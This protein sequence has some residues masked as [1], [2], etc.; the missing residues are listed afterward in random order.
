MLLTELI[1]TEKQ[2]MIAAEAAQDAYI[3]YRSGLDMYERMDPAEDM[4]SDELYQEV[5][6]NKLI[7]LLHW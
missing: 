3:D 6:E 2:L 4:A 5:Y 7:E 1:A